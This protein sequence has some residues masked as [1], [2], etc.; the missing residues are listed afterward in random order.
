MEATTQ[1]NAAIAKILLIYSSTDGHTQKIA[2]KLKQIIEQSRHQ[3]TVVPIEDVATIDISIFDKFVI[4]AS[5]RYGKHSSMIVDFIESNRDRLEAR[6]NAF[7]SVNLVARKPEKKDPENNPYL[8][9]F[10]KR[11]SW[12]PKHLEV[13]AGKVD[14]P[15]YRLI[16]RIMIQMIMWMTKGPTDA[17]TVIEY[18]DWDQVETFGNKISQM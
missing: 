2:L 14:Y 10:L 5:V 6:S 3:V 12:K 1:P 8:Q 17:N 4:G 13:I 18:T 15:S 11:L 16:D 7:F 9:K